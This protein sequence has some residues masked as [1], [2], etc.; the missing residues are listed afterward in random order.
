METVLITGA[1]RGIGLA[2]T[3]EF[4]QQG[5]SVLAT[6]RT[7]S[8]ELQALMSFGDLSIHSLDVT[9]ENSVTA[10]AAQLGTQR[11]DIL[12]NNA[13][14]FGPQTQTL[15]SCAT[16]DWLK[17]FAVNSIAPFN[18]S[19]AFLPHLKKSARPRILTI[20]SQLGSLHYPV[21]GYYAYCSTKA[22]ANQVTRILAAEL[23]PQGIIVCPLHPGWVKTD[24]GGS[25]AE[26]TPE[27]SAK[28]LVKLASELTLEQSG[29][30]LTWEGKLH[31]W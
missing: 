17:A 2:L 8:K 6:S 23:K 31:E 21:V 13:G 20:T 18:V 10:L 14:I 25:N 9:D 26:I 1:N 27:E 29:Q 19:K 30:F 22:A 11:I 4:L 12:F 24:M 15:E 3:K 16:E 5:F 7:P 28:G